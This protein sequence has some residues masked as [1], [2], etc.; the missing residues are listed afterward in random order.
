[1]TA[2]PRIRAALDETRRRLLSARTADGAWRGELSSSALSTAT[3][4]AALA[5]VD[6]RAHAAP[7]ARGVRW[8][9]EHANADG[10]WGDTPQ[11]RSNLPTTTLVW[12][13]L[14][15][16]PGREAP[17]ALL[18]RCEAYLAARC[19]GLSPEFVARAIVSQYGR[20]R[21][22]SA[23]I[24]A[25]CALAGRL[26]ERPSDAWALV[27]Q[28]P[29][30]LGILPHSLLRAARLPVVSYALPALIAVGQARDRYHPVACPLTRVVRRLV[31]R[32]SRNRLERLQPPG[33]GFLE[34]VPL[35]S[36][37]AMCLA[38]MGLRNHPVVA[39]SVAF[40]Q[41][42]QRADGSW[43]I[44]TDL[45]GWVT[46]LSVRALGADGRAALEPAERDALRAWLLRCQLRARHVFTGASPGGWAWTDQPGGVP[47][48]DD[49]AGALLALHALDD[50]GDATARAARAGVGWLAD[51]Q[52][53]D[54]GVPT[55][56]RGWGRLP[57]DRS[58]PDL[59]AHALL[60]WH[61]WRAL[62][63]A[64]IR[65]RTARA[66]ARAAEYLSGAQRADGAWIPLWFGNERAEDQANPVYGTARV[67]AALAELP[68]GRGPRLAAATSAG[69][70]FLLACRQGDGSWG[71]EAGVAPSIEET[72]VATDALAKLLS[73]G[74]PAGMEAEL[75][76]AVAGGLR[77][78]IERTEGGTRFDVSPIGLYFAR[79]W[80]S[81]ALYPV[82][83]TAAALARGL[84]VGL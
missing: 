70:R 73:F 51:L 72:A 23:P 19:G 49:T 30:E 50:G 13:A 67:L 58:A 84:R 74:R 4:V 5:R 76:A 83:F 25:M 31:A 60:A 2:D 37:V 45:S 56:C 24:L 20:D 3:A 38:A 42:A 11:S 1:V 43:P 27:P 21:T 12:S 52:N 15:I 33:G 32:A 80:Y 6:P 69:A 54:G 77:W 29:F 17:S 35:T 7:M 22:F 75:R 61:R 62:G 78:L 36:F 68:E 71:A 66:L 55:F 59:T 10:G 64:T 9:V 65:R 41:A 40:L 18:A 82:I 48:A 14:A 28:L 39:R 47:D 79:L 53:R 63:D 46:S 44:D 16:S 8:L 81:E 26:G 34:A 57:F